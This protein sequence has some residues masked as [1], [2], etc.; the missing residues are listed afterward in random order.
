MEKFHPK[1]SPEL[2]EAIT[3]MQKEYF[4][5]TDAI[6]KFQYMQ[7]F[8]ARKLRMALIVCISL[9]ICQQWSGINAVTFN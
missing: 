9:M 6:G 4:A 1:D 3:D 7:L 2:E 5:S 8:R